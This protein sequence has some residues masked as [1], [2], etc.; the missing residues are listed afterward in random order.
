[1]PEIDADDAIDALRAKVIRVILGPTSLEYEL[2]SAYL[3]HRSKVLQQQIAEAKAE[4][5]AR[6]NA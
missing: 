5:R 3:R 6:I 4:L 2:Y 1:M